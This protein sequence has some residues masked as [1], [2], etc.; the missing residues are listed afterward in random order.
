MSDITSKLMEPFPQSAIKSRP[1]NKRLTYVEGVTVFRRLIS[2]TDNNFTIEVVNQDFRDFGSTSKGQGRLLLLATVK[3]TI[4]GL[5]SREHVGVQVVN[6]ENGGEDLWKGAITD[7]VKK[8]ATLF[9]VGLELY[10]PDFESEDYEPQAVPV[11]GTRQLR[12]VHEK[13]ESGRELR[14]AVEADGERG[15]DPVRE[16]PVGGRTLRRGGNRDDVQTPEVMNDTVTASLSSQIT[17]AEAIFDAEIEEPPKKGRSLVRQVKDATRTAAP[18]PEETG[19]V[20]LASDAQK[21]YL[22]GLYKGLGYVGEDGHTDMTSMEAWLKM[23]FQTTWATLSIDEA[24][25]AINDLQ[26]AQALGQAE[27]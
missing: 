13:P 26:S 2:A 11:Q 20:K 1:D 17:A 3:L 21:N 9:G 19:E 6:A 5:G 4:P 14:K 24:S 10:G 12:P 8:A 23:T 18:V 16:K 22:T 7:G 25:R 27:L 15:P